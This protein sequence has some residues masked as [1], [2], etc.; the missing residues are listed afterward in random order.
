MRSA[1]RCFAGGTWH[2][3]VY[4][5]STG[6]VTAKR[7][8]QGYSD[9]RFVAHSSARTSPTSLAAPGLAV[10]HGPSTASRTVRLH[11]NC[12]SPLANASSPVYAHT[13][14]EDY[15]TTARKV[16]DYFIAHVPQDGIVPW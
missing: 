1:E 16:A 7:T 11:V 14:I 4:S 12:V 2:V 6:Q 5:A 3:V 15:L 9:D 10:K 13:G 8:A